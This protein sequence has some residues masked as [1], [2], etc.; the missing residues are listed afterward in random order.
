ML[1]DI[2]DS[3]LARRCQCWLLASLVHSFTMIMIVIKESLPVLK[4]WKKSEYLH[5]A[6]LLA[7][8]L[9]P[10]IILIVSIILLAS[11]MKHYPM[12]QV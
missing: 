5:I 12:T 10:L 8:F 1:H 3:G 6:S 2:A 9:G 11:L 4:E 7:K